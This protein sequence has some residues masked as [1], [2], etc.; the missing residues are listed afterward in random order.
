M[1]A[2]AIVW[3]AVLLLLCCKTTAQPV[4]QIPDIGAVACCLCLAGKKFQALLLAQ[5]VTCLST[6]ATPSC[7]VVLCA[8]LHRQ[9][10]MNEVNVLAHKVKGE[11]QALDQANAAAVRKKGQGVGSASERTR[12]SITAGRQCVIIGVRI[13][14][15]QQQ[16][17]Q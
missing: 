5:L 10:V 12:T 1:L 8:A 17:Q 3:L 7:A 6:T 4:V 15:L 9:S 16:Q 13:R 14:N 11:I 2:H